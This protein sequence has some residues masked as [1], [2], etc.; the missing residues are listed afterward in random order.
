MAVNLSMLAGAGAQFFTDNGV[1]LSGGLV[2]TYAAGTTTPQAVYTSSSGL[3]AHTNPIVLNSAGRVPSGGEIWLTDA[4]AY[5]FVLQ[6]SLAVVIATYDNI[7]GNSSGV[8]ATFAAS[9]G[10]SLIGFIQ[11]GSSAVATTA[12][13]K[14]RV[15]V[16][17]TDFGAVAGGPDCTAAIHA[18]QTY[19]STTYGGGVIEIP[20]AQ[21]WFMNAVINKENIVIK[22]VGGRAEYNSGCIRPYSIATPTITFGDGVTAYYYMGLKNCHVSGAANTGGG[23]TLAANNAPNAVLLKGGVTKFMWRDNVLYNGLVT[24]EL[25]PSATQ[26]VTKNQFIGGNIRND[27]A[28][29]ASARAWK[30]TR[31][32]QNLGYYTDN[33]FSMV[34][35]NKTGTGYALEANGTGFAMVVEWSDAYFDVV[36]A[37]G[38]LIK[39]SVVFDSIRVQIDPG[40]T[41]VVVFEIDGANNDPLRYIRG[42]LDI[43]GQLFKSTLGNVT[44]PA[45]ANWYHYQ[46]AIQA[47]YLI[48]PVAWTNSN[49]PYDITLVPSEDLITSNGPLV[50]TAPSGT[51]EGGRSVRTANAAQYVSGHVSELVTLS[52]VAAF[53]V[54]AVIQ[55]PANSVIRSVVARVTTTI[56]P[57]AGG[58]TSFELGDAILSTRFGAGGALAS[59]STLVGITQVDQTGTAGPKQTTAASPRITL[60]GGGTNIPSAG[61]V[62]LTIFYDRFIAP[63]S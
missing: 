27:I 52:T 42:F 37:L 26:P 38:V 49:A 4:V 25:L 45:E 63:T 12:Q 21:N 13:A 35:V 41:G 46:P 28:D 32:D 22:G 61:V 54:P 39:G 15:S 33:K 57:G 9:S 3:T 62:R 16:S 8:Y 10:S 56:N 34:G 6:T 18:A 11:A 19:L 44:I 51:Q 59:G 1:I 24:L 47:P 36:P 40:T 43:S 60:T 20:T 14:M 23:A 53:T 31:I 48:G 29:S 30:G 7:T 55:M 50:I 58:A 5:K 2:Y 17:I